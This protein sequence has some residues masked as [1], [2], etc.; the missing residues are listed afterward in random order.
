MMGLLIYKYEP[1]WQEVSDT[2]VTVKACGP[3][4]Y[5]LIYDKY[6]EIR[7]ERLVC[8]EKYLERQGA[9]VSL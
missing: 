6:R 4:V 7:C 3:L 2:Q 8:D 1:F 9:Y 5:L